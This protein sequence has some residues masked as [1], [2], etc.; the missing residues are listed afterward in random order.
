MG[1]P[2]L[3]YLASSE[4][5]QIFAADS[6]EIWYDTNEEC[7]A[8]LRALPCRVLH[9]AQTQIKPALIYED[10]FSLNHWGTRTNL[11]NKN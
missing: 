1:Q 10:A 5:W 11:Y 3:R 9:L 2:S 4:A 7:Q 8:S 6:Y